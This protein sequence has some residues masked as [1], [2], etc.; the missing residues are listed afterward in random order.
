MTARDEEVFEL[1]VRIWSAWWSGAPSAIGRQ[2]S[3]VVVRLLSLGSREGGIS[4]SDLKRQLGIAQPRLSKL[5]KKLLRVGWIKIRKPGTGREF[6]KQD[7]RVRLMT[8]TAEGEARILSL[9][10][11]LAP[12]LRAQKGK[13]APVLVTLTNPVASRR[14]KRK[15]EQPGQIPFV[16]S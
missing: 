7:N 9:K 10:E 11:E 15:R 1:L 14:G 12:L 13:K 6:K 16:L 8:T 2:E 5:T 4:Q 3:S